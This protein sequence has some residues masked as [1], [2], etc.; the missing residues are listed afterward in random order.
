MQLYK[1]FVTKNTLV[2]IMYYKQLLLVSNDGNF[3]VTDDI[4]F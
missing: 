1:A 3:I 4:Q 2:G